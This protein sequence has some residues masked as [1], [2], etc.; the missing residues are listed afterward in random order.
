M[1]G[2]LGLSNEW[3]MEE[4]DIMKK[5]KEMMIKLQKDLKKHRKTVM[6]KFPIM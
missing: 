2:I 6:I 5:M 3:P 4:M 1:K